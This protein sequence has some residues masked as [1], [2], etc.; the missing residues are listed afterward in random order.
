MTA[1]TLIPNTDCAN[2]LGEA[3]VNILKNAFY[4]AKQKV[5][6]SRKAYKKLIK[7]WGWENE[8]K[9]YLKVNQTFKKFSPQD[10]AQ[11]EPA[12]IFCLANQNKKYAPVI[13]KLLDIS[14]ITQQTVRE[15]M[16]QQRKPKPFLPEKPTIWRQTRDGRRYWQPGPNYD[17]ETGVILQKLMDSTGKTPQQLLGEALRLKLAMLEGSLI[18]VPRNEETDANKVETEESYVSNDS[19]ENEIDELALYNQPVV[20]INNCETEVNENVSSSEIINST[21]TQETVEFLSSELFIVVENINNFSRKQSKEAELL[22]AQ[23]IDF[24]NAQQAEEQ[25]D[26]LAS[27]TL[28]N[29]KALMVVI[30]YSKKEHKNWFFNLSQLLADAALEN[31]E[32]LDWVDKRLRSEALLIISNKTSFSVTSQNV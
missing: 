16:K 22:I 24:C 9:K 23:I 18:E 7:E 19:S 27:I 25:W 1:A 4:L 21:T 30:G 3:T 17:Q 14:Y 13:E 32:E 12:T 15:L 28:R 20:E 31:P 2:S 11:V 5:E 29:S 8:D 6:L 10:L 26:T